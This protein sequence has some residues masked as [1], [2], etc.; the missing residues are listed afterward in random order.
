MTAGEKLLLWDCGVNIE[1]KREKG[2]NIEVDTASEEDIEEIFHQ[3]LAEVQRKQE[4]KEY[5]ESD[6]AVFDYDVIR[7]K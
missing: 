2:I 4:E 6:R 7:G 3:Q 5:N 1:M